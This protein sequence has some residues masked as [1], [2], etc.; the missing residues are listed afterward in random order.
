MNKTPTTLSMAAQVLPTADVE[1]PVIIPLGTQ[2]YEIFTNG[3]GALRVSTV[4]GNVA[5]SIEPYRQV[6]N[7]SA[8]YETD[9]ELRRPLTIYVA[10]DTAATTIVIQT[11]S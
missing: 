3:V 2:R 10:S 11:W 6:P 1:Y 8:W 7:G 4:M 5:T 9:I